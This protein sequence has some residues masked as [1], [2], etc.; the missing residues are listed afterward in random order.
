MSQ[1]VKIALGVSLGVILLLCCF[2]PLAWLGYAEYTHLTQ[3]RP[4][5]NPDTEGLIVTTGTLE[6]VVPQ[7]RWPDGGLCVSHRAL[8]GFSNRKYYA[9]VCE[10]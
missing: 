4:T 9:L 8:A 5:V 3:P 6:V 10:G 2:L 7:A 1:P